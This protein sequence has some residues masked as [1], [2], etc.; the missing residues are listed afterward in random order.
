MPSLVGA[1]WSPSVLPE[2]SQSAPVLV[3]VQ[4]REPLQSAK[5]VKMPL[6]HWSKRGAVGSQR[7][8]FS[9]E[10]VPP[11][12]SAGVAGARTPKQASGNTACA[13]SVQET[14][15]S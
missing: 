7:A 12:T 15:E 9:V 6:V 2:V 14:V 10:Q 13:M 4:P 3:V 5:S 1:Q 8:A 11:R